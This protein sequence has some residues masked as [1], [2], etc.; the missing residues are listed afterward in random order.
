VWSHL[1]ATTL[2]AAQGGYYSGYLG[3]A[4]VLGLPVVI[5]SVDPC[6]L[7]SNLNEN[8]CG[9]WIGW[10]S[11]RSRGEGIAKITQTSRAVSGG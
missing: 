11:G 3:Y 5:S 9:K 8:M 7:L 1:T 10:E 4:L 6:L 2:A